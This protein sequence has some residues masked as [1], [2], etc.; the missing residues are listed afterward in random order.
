[1]SLIFS[2]F[3]AYSSYPACASPVTCWRTPWGREEYTVK[4]AS[5]TYNVILNIPRPRSY[6]GL[7]PS[8]GSMASG[9]PS[10]PAFCTCPAFTYTV[11]L[12]GSSHVSFPGATGTGNSTP[13]MMCKHILAVRI[14][15]RL[16]K[17]VEKSLEGDG[18]DIFATNASS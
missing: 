10:P 8:T 14:A 16:D 2:I 12:P 17:C 7:H 6:A 11:L 5:D 9:V 18:I 4:G 3:F 1:M 13:H 15:Q